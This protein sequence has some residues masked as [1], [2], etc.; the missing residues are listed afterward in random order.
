MPSPREPF[1][2]RQP[3]A[4]FVPAVTPQPETVSFLRTDEPTEVKKPATS[5]PLLDAP[6][7]PGY[8]ITAEIARG[9]MGRVYAAF[10]ET[11]DRE[12]AIKTLLPGADAERFVTEAKITA[13]LPHPAIPPVHALGTLPDNTPWLAMKLIHGQ[14]LASL[15]PSRDGGNADD[16]SRDGGN[17][18]ALSRD[19]G[20]ADALSRDRKGAGNQRADAL[21]SP[22]DQKTSGQRQL[23]G[24]GLPQLIQIF[25]QIAQAVGF[26]HSRGIIHRDLKPLNV[27]VGEFGEVQVMDWGL[28]KDVSRREVDDPSRDADDPSRDRADADDPSRDRANA[29][30]PSRDRDNADDPSRDRKGAGNQ[31]ADALRSP[32]DQKASR[33]RELP[34]E[35]PEHTA[36]GT[37]L[38]TPGYMAPEQARGEAVDQRADVFAL[39]S[40][41]ATI[42]T[43]QPAFVGH[44]KWEILDKSARAD[45]SEVMTRLDACTADAELIALCKRCLSAKP[46]D[47]PKDG[48]AVAAEVAAYRASVEQRLRQAETDRARAETQAA[49]QR[50]RRRVV[51]WA[52]G[53]IAAVLLAGIIGTTWGLI[54]A[55]RAREA[56][57]RR[58]DREREAKLLEQ[59]AKEK[60]EVSAAAE[61]KAN[62]TAQRRLAQI[63]KGVELFAEML[64]GI[65]PLAEEQ[66][67]DPLYVQ[68]RQ[69][70][71]KAADELIAESV[72]DPLAVARLQTILGNTL[73]ELGDLSKSVVVLER[74]RATR[75]RELGADHPDTLTTLNNLAMAFRDAGR[76]PE[77]ITLLEQVRAAQEQKLGADHPDTLATLNNLAGAYFTAGRLPETI[78]LCEQV[79]AAREKKLGADHPDT[80]TRLNNLAEG[81]RDAGKLD[82]ALPLWEETLK[83]R[84][85]KLGADH[86]DTLTSMNNLANGYQAAGK[87]DLAL[88]LYEETLKLKKAK[89]G[90]DHPDTLTSMNNLAS[91]YWA[92]GKLDLA[93]PL[94]EETLK[95]IKAKL[96]DDHPNTLSS[97]NNLAVGYEA[98]GKLDLALPLYEETLKLRKAKLGADHPDTLATLHNLAGAYQAAGR[99][100]EAIAL[101]EQVRA[102]REKKL[103]ADHP[104]TLSSMHRLAVGYHDTGKLELALLLYEEILKLRKVK[105]GAD[106]PDTLKSAYDLALVY[107]DQGKTDAALALLVELVIPPTT[108]SPTLVD[109]L[110]A[111]FDRAEKHRLAGEHHHAFQLHKLVYSV[112]REKLGPEHPTT[113][114]SLNSLGW[115]E[116]NRRRYEDAERYFRAALEGYQC[117][118]GP[119]H[120]GTLISRR[121]LARLE[122]DR[123]RFDS[124]ADWLK[125]ILADCQRALGPDHPQTLFTLDQ[126]A[127][128]ER[129]RG[130]YAEAITLLYQLFEARQ[131]VLG[132][133]H[134]IAFDMRNHVGLTKIL[135]GDFAGAEVDL[136]AT[137]TALIGSKEAPKHWRMGYALRLACLYAE[138]GKPHEV[139]KWIEEARQSAGNL[140]IWVEECALHMAKAKRY[141][142]A[143]VMW[144]ELLQ[145]KEVTQ[146]DHWTTANVMS[147]VGGTLLQRAKLLG[148][149]FEQSRLLAEAEPLLIKGYVG[150]KQREMTIPEN[151][152]RARITE[153]LDRLIELY[154]VLNR[155]EEVEKYRTLRGQSSEGP[156]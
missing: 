85:A 152:R 134:H 124:A 51:Q 61:K 146:P 53:I 78:T 24:L 59:Q 120:V 139:K 116:H 45:L 4:D 14:T 31:R 42:L 140:P 15:L 111:L 88:P 137:W 94:W 8:R 82:L 130:R 109:T 60:A 104:A 150:L 13:R 99:L 55:N 68:L 32:S 66:G 3:T 127:F 97:M 57:K 41:L 7:I 67:G 102:A 132:P 122:R 153:A 87:L 36:A 123:G 72:A 11:L 10:D 95:L 69:R 142:A 128:L 22:S 108:R 118:H 49:E 2:P 40:I 35:T 56:E 48:Q 113:L 86:P 80:L 89:L 62:E 47:R 39:G 148:N 54:E 75:E 76:L 100:P 64:S 93:L 37:I 28:A 143:S 92:A 30:D 136:L 114:D 91:G 126:L 84:K 77:A 151:L 21:R 65:N 103:G 156:K 105:L 110:I 33:Q 115:V 9:G 5:P 23:P 125:L 141:S 112:R 121:N 133:A 149:E 34:G 20:N 29:D 74:A 107:Q 81:Y 144:K 154:T 12:V 17:A 18:D 43:G 1:D 63:E 44:S 46:E 90:A 71:A 119:D 38:G 101:Y 52:G 155:P 26:A 131:R 106:H 145:W 58:A 25:E 70:A 96:G 27:M 98:A 135:H 129:D 16:P 117:A 73:R 147:L 83:L 50:K 6:T 19:G 79:R 138:L